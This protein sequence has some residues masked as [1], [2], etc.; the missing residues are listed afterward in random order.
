[1]YDPDPF[2]ARREVDERQAKA[3]QKREEAVQG[4]P[5]VHRNVTVSSEFGQVP[6]VKMASGLRDLVEDAV[7]KV[8][9]SHATAVKQEK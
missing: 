6:E 1:M 7:K 2:A 9:G 5:D 4:N 8:G 3:S